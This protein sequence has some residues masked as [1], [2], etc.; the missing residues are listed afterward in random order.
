MKRLKSPYHWHL[1]MLLALSGAGDHQLAMSLAGKRYGTA[2]D[3][4]S[5]DQTYVRTDLRR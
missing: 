2:N 1:S 5:G 3:A 4:L